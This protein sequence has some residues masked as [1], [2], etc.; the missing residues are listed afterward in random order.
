MKRIYLLIDDYV[1]LTFLET[2]LKKVGFDTV[3]YQGIM[4]ASDKALEILPD[5]LILSDFI[6]AQTTADALAQIKKLRPQMKCLLLRKDFSVPLTH[7]LKLIDLT[8]KS[9]IDPMDFLK[10]VSIILQVDP[11]MVVDKFMKLGL[12][13]GK[14]AE[15]YIKVSSL[16]NGPEVSKESKATS[17]FESKVQDSIHVRSSKY[18]EVTKS[19]PEAKSQVIDSKT[20]SREASEFRNRSGDKEIQ[21]ID[22]ERQS[23]VKA[24]FKK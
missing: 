18:D 21:K 6:K 10:H 13:R 15:S 3:G 2:I 11:V 4:N 9:P 5:L 20:A 24:L 22:E 19:I 14:E 16:S 23:F 8:L 1:E 12:F 17:P 7:D